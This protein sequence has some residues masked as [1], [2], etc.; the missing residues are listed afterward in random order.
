MNKISIEVKNK[1]NSQLKEY[2]SMIKQM[3]K[4]IIKFSKTDTKKLYKN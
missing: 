3:A 2:F 4:C 1:I